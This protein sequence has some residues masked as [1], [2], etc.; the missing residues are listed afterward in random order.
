MSALKKNLTQPNP[1]NPVHSIKEIGIEMA[2][3]PPHL[4]DLEGILDNQSSAE[5]VL[6]KDGFIQDGQSDA[7]D[8]KQLTLEE[9]EARYRRLFE[10]AKDGILILNGDT[11]RIVDANPFL[12]DMLGYSESELVGKALWEIGPVKDIPAS[13]DAMRELQNNEYIRY[14]DIPLETKSGV[15]KHVEFVSNVY[16]VNGWRVIQ[17]NIR[18]ITERKQAEERAHAANGKLVT[19][20]DELKRR[21]REMMLLNRMNDLLQSCVTLVEAYQVLTLNMAELLPGQNGCLALLH[22]RGQPLETV[23]CWGPDVI[24]E[25]AFN[26]ENCWALRRGQLHE[27]LDPQSGLLCQHFIHPPQTAYVCLPLMVQGETLGVLSLIDTTKRRSEHQLGLQQLAVMIGETVKLAIANLK[28]R[29]QLRQQAIHD[30]LTGLFNRRY[31]DETLPRD[32]HQ[33]QRRNSPLCVVM[34]DIDDFKHFNDAFGHGPADAV[35]REL[36]RVLR[37]K[38]RKSDISCRYGGDEFVL[39]LHDSSVAA[40]QA[41]LEQIRTFLKGLEINYG[42]QVLGPIT[43]SIGIVQTPEHSITARDLLREADEAMYA[44]KQAGRDRIVVYH[45]EPTL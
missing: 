45:R 6:P 18:D 27:V 16:K 11:G 21:D 33:A 39:V 31:L 1:P 13:Q 15:H 26:L 40:T 12:Q 30:Q 22:R 3:L 44:A 4:T 7:H 42:E 17:C 24:V 41:R 38:L 8:P 29:D 2:D 36:G 43:L 25:P 28:L 23:A 20:V 32:L 14:E 5:S 37:E 9:S 10:T 19:L 34:L 35:L